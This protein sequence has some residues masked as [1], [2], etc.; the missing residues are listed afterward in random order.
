VKN[1]FKVCAFK[2]NLYCYVLGIGTLLGPLLFARHMVTLWAWLLVRLWE[3]VED[4]SGY[5]LPFNPT[6][7]IPFWGGA[8]HHDFHH[9]TFDGPYASIFTWCDWMFGTD[10]VGLCTSRIQLTRSLKAPGFNNP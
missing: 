8:V 4:H 1:R 6:N 2:R 9:K 7:F 5:D 10:K 3:T